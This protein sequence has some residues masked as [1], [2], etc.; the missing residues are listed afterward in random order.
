MT[1]T[2]GARPAPDTVVSATALKKEEKDMAMTVKSLPLS[3]VI[4]VFDK[5]SK[6]VMYSGTEDSIPLRI[7]LQRPAKI[8]SVDDITYI[9]IAYQKVYHDTESDWYF[10]ESF[11]R[12]EY[13]SD[14]D[15]TR[16]FDEYMKDVLENEQVWEVKK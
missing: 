15:E 14:P 16:T 3:G 11:F 5:K 6:T 8:Y 10:Y 2:D 1:L 4:R 12:E 9:D 13:E 7:Q